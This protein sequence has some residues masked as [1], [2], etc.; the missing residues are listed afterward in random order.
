MYHEFR[1]SNRSGW[2]YTYKGQDLIPPAQSKLAEYRQKEIDERAKMAKMLNDRTCSIQ[3]KEI[4]D[5]E[6]KIADYGALVE[7]LEVFCYEFQRTPDRDFILA[8]GD[9]VFFGLHKDD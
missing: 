9:V 5:C 8:L 7:Q 3:S 1:D 2:K 6:K 4:Q